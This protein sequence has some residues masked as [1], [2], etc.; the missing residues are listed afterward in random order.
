MRVMVTGLGLCTSVGRTVPETWNAVSN[1]TAGVKSKI[2]ACNKTGLDP[3]CCVGFDGF[4]GALALTHQAVAEAFSSAGVWDGECLAAV[5]PSRIG[6]TFSASKPLA[7]A[8][9]WRAPDEV[10]MGV[11]RHFGLQGESRNVIAA[12]AT[13]V[14]SIALGASWIEAGL[15][16]VVLCGSAEPPVHPLMAAGFEQMGVVSADAWMRPFDRE[17]SGFV[18]GFGAGALVLESETHARARGQKAL[19]VLSGWGLGADAHSAFAFNSN[20]ARIADVVARAIARARLAP[21]AI[22]HVNAHGTATRLNDW[23]ETQALR[24]AFGS[25]A[26]RLKISATKSATGHLLGAAGSVEAAL[27]VLALQNQFIPPTSTLETPDP[28]CGLDYTPGSGHAEAFDH[29]L[30]L[31]FGFGGSIGALIFSAPS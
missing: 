9:S 5:D 8:G 19:A 4:S 31:S 20:G 11:V 3:R 25:H 22:R 12:C 1:A 10:T 21:E 24:K 2:V 29:A 30:S 13:G 23:L 14:Y 15:C 27:T 16:D 28:E 17:R 18:F 26:E 6:C 7:D